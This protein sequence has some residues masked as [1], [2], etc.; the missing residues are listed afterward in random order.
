[1]CF[2]AKRLEKKI[3]PFYQGCVMESLDFSCVKILIDR[4]EC[5]QQA[6]NSP[7]FSQCG[8]SKI[9]KINPFYSNI[10]ND[11]EWEDFS[12]QISDLVVWKLLTD[13]NTDKNAKETNS[14]DQTDSDN[15]I[16]GNDRPNI[17]TN[18]IVMYHLG[19]VRFLLLLLR[20]LFG[21]YLHF[22][23]SIPQEKNT[24]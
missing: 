3:R 16:E 21:K 24:L 12:E 9:N 13:K 7:C 2:S 18:E 15:D 19:K 4:Q 1:M 22:L 20:I 23:K 17:S 5:D 14:R 11:N 10:T 6:I 8:T